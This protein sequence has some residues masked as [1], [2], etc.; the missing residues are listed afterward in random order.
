MPNGLWMEIRLGSDICGGDAS[1]RAIHTSAADG[2][3]NGR[4][5]LTDQVFRITCEPYA[6]APLNELPVCRVWN[7]HP[8]PAEE[9]SRF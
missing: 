7:Y 4:Y 8:S 1:V 2:N 3:G 9:S 5:Q 6:Y